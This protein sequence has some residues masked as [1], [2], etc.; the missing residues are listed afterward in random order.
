MFFQHLVSQVPP[1]RLP[2]LDR[3]RI[4]H[5][6]V[7]LVPR[8][9]EHEAGGESLD[10]AAL[11]NRQPAQFFWVANAGSAGLRRR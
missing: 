9:G 4:T 5:L 10:C 6:T 7:A 1:N 11:L 3:N 2:E 8:T